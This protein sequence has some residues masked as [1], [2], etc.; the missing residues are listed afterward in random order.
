[1][2]NQNKEIF[3]QCLFVDGTR[4]KF[5]ISQEEAYRLDKHVGFDIDHSHFIIHTARGTS[6]QL[7]HVIMWSYTQDFSVKCWFEGD[8]PDVS[9][10]WE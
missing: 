8:Q 7:K 4:M 1:M 10:D 6:I 2:T 9:Q 5:A 3:I